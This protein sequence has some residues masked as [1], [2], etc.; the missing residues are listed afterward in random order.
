MKKFF[1]EVQSNMIDNRCTT[2]TAKANQYTRI[3]RSNMRRQDKRLIRNAMSNAHRQARAP[4]TPASDTSA[5]SRWN[6]TR[7]QST[8]DSAINSTG[9]RKNAR[10]RC[11]ICGSKRQFAT[12]YAINNHRCV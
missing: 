8:A 11:Q 10:K 4:A 1:T 3:S 6:A 7:Y 9:N 5:G 12:A 2:P